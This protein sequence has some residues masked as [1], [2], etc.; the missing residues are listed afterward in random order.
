MIYFV[1]NFPTLLLTLKHLTSFLNLLPL[2]SGL[3]LLF[4]KIAIFLVYQV[5][6]LV[7]SQF[8]LMVFSLIIFKIIIN[9]FVSFTTPNLLQLLPQFVIKKLMTP[10]LSL[11]F[12]IPELLPILSKVI[13]LVQVMIPI[14]LVNFP[15]AL[16]SGFLVL[17]IQA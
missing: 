9:S 8:I 6:F 13:L 10:H 3:K 4:S 11:Q 15:F 12:P 5:Q 17:L 16:G 1:L 2:L 7:Q 14:F